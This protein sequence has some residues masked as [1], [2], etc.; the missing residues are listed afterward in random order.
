D[1]DGRPDLYN[2]NI[3]HWWAGKSADPAELLI[4]S[5]SGSGNI[6]FNRLTPAQSG[7]VIPHLDPNGWNE[8]LVMAAAADLDSDGRPDLIASG[9][10]YPYQF[11]WIFH[12]LPDAGFK[13]VGQQWGIHFPCMSGLSVADF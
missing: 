13:E 11:G 4:N 2:A 1:G 9:T 5:S 6:G 7:L 3:S 10:D 12:Q 8:G